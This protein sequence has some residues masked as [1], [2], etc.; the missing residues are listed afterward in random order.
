LLKKYC[1]N[2]HLPMILMSVSANLNSIQF[3]NLIKCSEFK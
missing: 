2:N 3:L 1:P